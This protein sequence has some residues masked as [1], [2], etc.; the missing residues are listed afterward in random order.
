[1]RREI[2]KLCLQKLLS[3]AIICVDEGEDL[4]R[5]NSLNHGFMAQGLAHNPE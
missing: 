4:S 5:L 1:M 3:V 2:L